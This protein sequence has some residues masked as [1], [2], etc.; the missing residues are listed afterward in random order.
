[1]LYLLKLSCRLCNYEDW[2][3]AQCTGRNADWFCSCIYVRWALG[4]HY[5]DRFSS[6]TQWAGWSQWYADRFIAMTRYHLYMAATSF[7]GWILADTPMNHTPPITASLH[8]CSVGNDSFLCRARSQNSANLTYI[9]ECM[10]NLH[11]TL[12]LICCIFML[13]LNRGAGLPGMF[14]LLTGRTDMKTFCLNIGDAISI[15]MEGGVAY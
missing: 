14:A 4:G 1:M 3:R 5:T 10:L 13:Q 8:K 12:C 15:E 11:C 7:V 9:L 6:T 2:E